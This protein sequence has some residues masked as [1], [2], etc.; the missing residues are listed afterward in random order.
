MATQIL[1]TEEQAIQ[2]AKISCIRQ[3]ESAEGITVDDQKIIDAKVWL[4]QNKF[5]QCN[6]GETGAVHL[7]L[8]ANDLTIDLLDGQ[9]LCDEDEQY[10]SLKGICEHCGE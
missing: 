10:C 3:L 8:F 1:K 7:V 9:E 4:I 2:A 6:C 5:C